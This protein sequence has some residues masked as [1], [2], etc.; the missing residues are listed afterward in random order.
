MKINFEPPVMFGTKC[1]FWCTGTIF[2]EKSVWF[3]EYQISNCVLG[4]SV[5]V[6]VQK[7]SSIY[8]DKWTMNVVLIFSK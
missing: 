7:V 5:W 8:Q 4:V 3:S 6:C 1:M 2:G